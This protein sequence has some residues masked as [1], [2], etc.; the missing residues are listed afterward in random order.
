[1]CRFSA[2]H[3]KKAEGR[4]MARANETERSSAEGIENGKSK[5]TSARGI[6]ARNAAAR[7]LAVRPGTLPSA[8]TALNPAFATR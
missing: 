5:P 1:M 8:T 4:P 2:F 6:S 3:P 7:P